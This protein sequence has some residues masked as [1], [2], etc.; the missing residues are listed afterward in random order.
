MSPRGKSNRIIMWQ[1]WG[2]KIS[3]NVEINRL[4]IGRK[5]PRRPM[6]KWNV[7]PV[8]RN[9]KEGPESIEIGK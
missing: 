8:K 6:N 7:L 3:A 1:E 4:Q 5:N 2:E 9:N